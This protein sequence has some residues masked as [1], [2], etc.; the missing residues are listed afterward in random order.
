MYISSPRSHRNPKSVTDTMNSVGGSIHHFLLPRPS[1]PWPFL[2]WSTYVLLILNPEKSSSP[3]NFTHSLCD[4]LDSHCLP[5]GIGDLPLGFPDL[6]TLSGVHLS[7]QL[8]LRP[9]EELCSSLQLPHG[10]SL[11]QQPGWVG[12]WLTRWIHGF[13]NGYVISN[14][15]LRDSRVW[16]WCSIVPCSPQSRL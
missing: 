5:C 16:L 1:P 14:Q 2:W 13:M 3:L 11:L 10:Q 6:Q 8:R 9:E 7:P 12:D 4:P 15:L